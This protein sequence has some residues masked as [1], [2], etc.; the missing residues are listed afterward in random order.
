LTQ[1]PHATP[2]DQSRVATN[3][4]SDLGDVLDHQ[5][6]EILG[7]SHRPVPDG[8]AIN[9]CSLVVAAAGVRK[10]RLGLVT[11]HQDGGV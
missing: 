11:G 10:L 2:K 7:Q 3:G 6:A 1:R 5:P 4:I 9:A 8:F